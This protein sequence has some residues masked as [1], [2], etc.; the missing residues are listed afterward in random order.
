MSAKI[1]VL[2]VA[3]GVDR[4]EAAIFAGLQRAGLR[5]RV[6]HAPTVPASA[7]AVLAEAGIP[8]G[9]LAVRHRLDL[10]AARRLRDGL[11]RHSCD[12]VYAPINRTLSVTLLATRGLG[13]PV[14][15]YRGTTGH[16]SRWDPASW[17]TYFHPRLAHVV[18][19][20]DAVRAY[21]LSVGLPAGRLTRIYKGHDPDWYAPR[22]PD[23]PLPAPAPGSL[24][25]CFAGRIRPVKGVRYLLDALELIPAEESVTLVLAGSVDE[26]AVRRRLARGG[27]PHRVLVLGHRKDATAIIGRCD[28]L[29]MPSVAR[30]GLPRAV[31]EAMAQGVAVVASGVG[32]LP[33]I[34]RD[35]ETGIVVPPRDAAALA[36]ALRRLRA[37]PALRARLGAAGR[38]RVDEVLHVRQSVAAYEALFRRLAGGAR[39]EG[40]AP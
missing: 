8:A 32:G 29:A 9:E 30:E 39:G 14:V 15:G 10:A 16:L 21:L 23:P 24:Q 18:C 26:P 13:V 28:V 37:D 11:A 34:V 36:A 22:A 12:L 27:W 5:L 40:S 35:S 4:S 25:V 38:R 7:R 31:V 1:E 3:E 6:F 2:V 19:V 33:E 20:S 17:L